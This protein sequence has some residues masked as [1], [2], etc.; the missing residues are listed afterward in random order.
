MWHQLIYK[1]YMSSCIHPPFLYAGKSEPREKSNAGPAPPTP[2][3]CTSNPELPLHLQVARG[4]W[5]LM[6]CSVSYTV[7]INL[8]KLEHV[9]VSRHRRLEDKINVW[10]FLGKYCHG[11]ELL[12]RLCCSC[13]ALIS[14]GQDV[15]WAKC[16]AD[17]FLLKLET[18]GLNEVLI[19]GCTLLRHIQNK[20]TLPQQRNESWTSYR[21]VRYTITG[22]TTSRV[23][24]R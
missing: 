15:H 21:C 8:Q 20:P 14:R 1:Y 4:A 18:E 5:I 9:C 6:L 24:S 10:K 7:Y 3:L 16:S 2:Q 11:K 12:C 23:L 13:Y 22:V 17:W 19:N